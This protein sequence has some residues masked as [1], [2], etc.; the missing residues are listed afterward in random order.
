MTG[1]TSLKMRAQA[2]MTAKCSVK[3]MK[4]FDCACRVLIS[5]PGSLDFPSQYLADPRTALRA[6]GEALGFG[7]GFE[8][9]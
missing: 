3:K 4:S 1:L 5:V 7:Q 2:K 6:L 8:C 9:S